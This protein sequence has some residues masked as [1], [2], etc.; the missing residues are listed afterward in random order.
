VILDDKNNIYGTT[1]SGGTY[2]SGVLFKL[3]PQGTTYK[4]SVLH[5]FKGPGYSDGAHPD[6]GLT[7]VGSTLY[8]T[9][10]DGGGHG[11][12]DGT[13]YRISTTGSDYKV[14]YDFVQATGS[15]PGYGALFAS[16][17]DL[18]GTTQSGGAGFGVVY[19][20]VP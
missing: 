17:A 6:A 19:K 12:N 7:A 11:N 20:F 15:N 10:V 1:E 3:S 5:N 8:G 2:G 16:G 14:L 18:Y 13:I 9:T 4:E